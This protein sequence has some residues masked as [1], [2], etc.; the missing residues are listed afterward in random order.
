MAY[1]RHMT[2]TLDVVAGVIPQWTLGDRLRKAREH[3][4]LKSQADLA[5]ELG[6]SRGSVANYEQGKSRP[7]RPILIAWALRTGVPLSW[8]TEGNGGSGPTSPAP[9]S[10]DGP[11]VTRAYLASVVNIRRPQPL[12]SHIREAASKYPDHRDF[13]HKTVETDKLVWQL[14][15]PAGY[16]G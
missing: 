16:G 10:P 13:V 4:G 5:T 2:S 11:E 9:D 1:L 7:I 6:I 14:E 8:L 15:H 12:H 3:A